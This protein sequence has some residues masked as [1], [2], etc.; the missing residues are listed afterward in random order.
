VI[1]AV[2]AYLY[3][4]HFMTA[5]FI[6]WIA[7]SVAIAGGVAVSFAWDIT[8]GPLLVVAFGVVLILAV[9]VKP[10]IGRRLG[11][12]MDAT[13]VPEPVGGSAHD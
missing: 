11:A 12:P 2:I 6:A 7:G 13:D 8:T 10:V 5:L 4:T 1:P 3:T 9:L